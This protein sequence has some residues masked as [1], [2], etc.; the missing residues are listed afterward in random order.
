MAVDEAFYAAAERR[1]EYVTLAIGAAGAL[2]AV[3]FWSRRAGVGVALGAILSWLK[4]DLSQVFGALCFVDTGSVC[5]P[6]SLK[7]VDSKLTGWICRCGACGA[8]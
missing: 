8:R 3:V 7:P 5:Y 1:I 2:C 4:G 6:Y